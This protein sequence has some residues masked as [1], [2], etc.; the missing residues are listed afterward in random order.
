VPADPIQIELID[1]PDRVPVGE[2]VPLHLVIRCPADG[3][4]AE[5]RNIA[6][7]D[8]KVAE[9]DADLFERDLLLQ[10]GEVY[11]CTVVA[12]FHSVG[13]YPDP[14]FFVQVGRDRD[15]ARPRVPT[16]SIRVVPSLAGE[17]RVVAESICTY[18]LGTKVD[19]TLTHLGVTTFDD[20]RLTVGPAD[21]LRTG[22]SE[23]RR[24]TFGGGDEIKLTAVL[25]AGAVEL[26]LDA[27]VGGMPVGPVPV[28]VPVAPVR[29]AASAPMFRFLEPRKLT[30]AD[31]R[32]RTTDETAELVPPASGV[33]AVSGGG[34]KY[35]VEIRPHA[36][37]TGVRL[38][39]VSGSVEVADIPS[40]AGTWA[41][42]LVVVTSPILTTPVTLHFDV[43]AADGPQQG[44]LN[45]AVRPL[46]TK[47]WLV[48]ATA[49]AAVTVKGIAAVVPALLSPGDL[50]VALGQA[51]T[52]VDTVWDAVQ[53]LSIPLIRGG[54][55]VVDQLTRPFQDV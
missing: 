44:E 33:F 27:S 8:P 15:T 45:L 5:L 46:G 47:L 23:R 10:P 42:Q 51:L 41:F 16:P 20:F 9:L 31:V 50:W 25:G 1:P 17:V 30:H 39:G 48:A 54:L 11:R 3:R 38:R 37:A 6:P 19:F 53:F 34:T 12:R 21:A 35:R 18:D 52:K 2:P 43:T 49:G 40:G 55:W 22:V 4:S 36:A 24:P 28:R 26:T 29:D 14:L 32:L 13:V 7:L